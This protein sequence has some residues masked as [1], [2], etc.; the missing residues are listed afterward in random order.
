M[1]EYENEVQCAHNSFITGYILK[2]T[3]MY[4]ISGS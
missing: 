2:L 4:I 1:A 3:I